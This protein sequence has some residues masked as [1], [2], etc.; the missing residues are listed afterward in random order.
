[1]PGTMKTASQSVSLRPNIHPQ[2]NVRPISGLIIFLRQ[3]QDEPFPFVVSLSNRKAQEHV[4]KRTVLETTHPL[5]SSGVD[6]L[7]QTLT[8]GSWGNPIAEAC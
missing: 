3:A 6:V 8:P 1:M 2:L 7:H 5:F 4:S